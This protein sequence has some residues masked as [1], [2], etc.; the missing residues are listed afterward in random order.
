MVAQT[1]IIDTGCANLNSVYAAFTRLGVEVCISQCPQHITAAKR[2][3]LPGVGSADPAM[4]SLQ[5]KGLLP[6]LASL[7]QPVLGICLG[8]QLLTRSSS[9]TQTSQNTALS[10]GTALMGNVAKSVGHAPNA[11]FPHDVTAPKC[12]PMLGHIPTKV[13]ALNSAGQPLPHMGWNTLTPSAHPLFAGITAS[14]YFY[15]VHSYCVPIGPHTLAESHYGMAFSAAIG[16]D[17][18]LGVQFHPEKSAAAGAKVLRNFM[19]IS[20]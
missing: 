9:E 13:I 7:T 3:I 15:F 6:V 17:N 20:A 10:N 1:V 14:D 12:T 16:R 11:I 4:A 2:V 19:E 8:M 5:A 18:W